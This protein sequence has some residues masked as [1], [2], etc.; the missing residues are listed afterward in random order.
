[1][2]RF[3]VLAENHSTFS[4]MWPFSRRYERLPELDS[5]I[6]SSF[7]GTQHISPNKTRV[8][9]LIVILLILANTLALGLL[10]PSLASQTGSK[11]PPTHHHAASAPLP[12]SV[13][14]AEPKQDCGGT[15]ESARAANCSFDLLSNSWLPTSCYDSETDLEFRSWIAHPNRTH[16]AWPYFTSK[17][18]SHSTRIL[19]VEEL[20][21]TNGVWLWSTQEQHLGHCIFWAKRVHRALEGRTKQSKSVENVKHSSHCANE[22]MA[23]LLEDAPQK[24]TGVVHFKVQID[25]C[26]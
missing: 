11:P 6:A 21:S 1:L 12:T 9:T 22:L 5:G 18:L 4:I 25:A 10:I 2:D 15:V 3:R 16:G 24:A 23:S 8:P 19:D 14:T 7:N 26:A 20:S 17:T 13:S